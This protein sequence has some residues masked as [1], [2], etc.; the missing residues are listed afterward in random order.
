MCQEGASQD[1]T[2]SRLEP[3]APPPRPSSCAHAVHRTYRDILTGLKQKRLPNATRT[4]HND[5]PHVKR[6]VRICQDSLEMSGKDVS[7]AH[8]ASCWVLYLCRPSRKFVLLSLQALTACSQKAWDFSSMLRL[9]DD[10]NPRQGRGQKGARARWTSLRLWRKSND[11]NA[12]SEHCQ[13]E[14]RFQFV[15]TA[16][17]PEGASARK[18]Q[19]HGTESFAEALP[20][21][22]RSFT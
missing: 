9:K 15:K 3:T 5:C 4:I 6:K 10:G 18:R 17:A 2:K 19:N 8:T 22:C 13:I 11:I 1:C 16:K 14:I 7:I 12:L 21:P 20:S